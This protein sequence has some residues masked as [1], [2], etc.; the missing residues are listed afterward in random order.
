M[1]NEEN[2]AAIIASMEATLRQMKD[3]KV[4]MWMKRSET[5]AESSDNSQNCFIFTRAKSQHEQ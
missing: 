5:P 2:V 3:I 1:P 4:D